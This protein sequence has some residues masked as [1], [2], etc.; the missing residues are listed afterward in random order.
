MTVVRTVH[1]IDD[2]EAVRESLA[3]L[4]D[5]AGY[6]VKTY[7][8]GARFLDGM[9]GQ[10]VGCVITDVRMPGLTGLELASRL[11]SLGSKLPLVVMTGHGDVALAVEAMKGGA[12]DFIEKPFEEEIILNAVEAALARADE[13]G[14]ERARRAA[15]LERL[16]TLSVRER[17]VL[18]GLVAGK[19]NKTIA[20]ELDISPRTVEVYRA[21]VM[22]KM[23]AS[24][25][26]HLVRMAIVAGDTH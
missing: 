14:E 3:F 9:T 2:D 5:A 11:K 16:G 23:Q 1:V 18:D 10:E 21:A 17:E 8:S 19:A 12:Q 24:S 15:A 13:I 7:D 26:S 20:R 6:E 22:T 4:L 25:L